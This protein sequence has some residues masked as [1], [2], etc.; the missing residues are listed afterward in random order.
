MEVAD[1]A[2]RVCFIEWHTFIFFL[3]ELKDVDWSQF[4]VIF[5]RNLVVGIRLCDVLASADRLH[6]LP[7]FLRSE[8]VYTGAARM[9]FTKFGKGGSSRKTYTDCSFYWSSWVFRRIICFFK[10]KFSFVVL[11]FR[12]LPFF[13]FL[14][15]VNLGR[16]QWPLLRSSSPS[17]PAPA[18]VKGPIQLLA[19]FLSASVLSQIVASWIIVPVRTICVPCSR[20]SCITYS[21]SKLGDFC[22][23]DG[24]IWN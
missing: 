13:R 12:I 17:T 7:S 4:W 1:S 3:F 22:S 6:V 14:F 19:V 21:R 5:L 20:P 18:A 2:L 16:G 24:D 10:N 8:A 11:V 23:N 15:F 9:M